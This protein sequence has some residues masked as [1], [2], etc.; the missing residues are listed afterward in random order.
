MSA[1]FMFFES[2][3]HQQEH[4]QVKDHPLIPQAQLML[5]IIQMLH[6]HAQHRLSGHHAISPRPTSCIVIATLYRWSWQRGQGASVSWSRGPSAGSSLRSCRRSCRT[7]A[8]KP[9]WLSPAA[10]SCSSSVKNWY[11]LCTHAAV[12]QRLDTC[13]ILLGFST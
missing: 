12:S 13:N 5:A 2:H 9:A 11:A 10:R 8:W 3:L 6:E 1:A 7:S 4:A